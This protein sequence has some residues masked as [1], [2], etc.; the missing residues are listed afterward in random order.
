MRKS[1]NTAWIDKICI[2]LARHQKR[3]LRHNRLKHQLS[4][5]RGKAL[6]L[7]KFKPNTRYQRMLAE[8]AHQQW[9]RRILAE[10]PF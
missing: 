6:G 8:R 2:N 1:M 10:S 3:P 9:I 4:I 7:P 5:N